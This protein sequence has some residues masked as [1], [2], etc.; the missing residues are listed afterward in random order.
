MKCFTHQQVYIFIFFILLNKI[1]F[2]FF[3]FHIRSHRTHFSTHPTPHNHIFIQLIINKSKKN[4]SNKHPPLPLFENKHLSF[5]AFLILLH[6]PPPNITK[7]TLN[8]CK[9]RTYTLFFFS[10]ISPPNIIKI[11]IE[12]VK[13]NTYPS[14]YTTPFFFSFIS[15]EIS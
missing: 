1:F 15:P 6:L 4:N 2:F 8:R 12:S 7:L 10:F 3:V 9:I 13:Y 5:N 14:T 11:N